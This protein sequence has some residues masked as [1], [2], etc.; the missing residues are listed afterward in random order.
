MNNQ[1]T[2]EFDFIDGEDYVNDD[3]ML[4]LKWDVDP[5]LL[6]KL[7]LTNDKYGVMRSIIAELIVA[8]ETDQ[9]IAY[10]RRRSFYKDRRRYHGRGFT[11][12]R[13]RKAIDILAKSDYVINWIA[14]ARRPTKG[15]KGTQSTIYGMP[16]LIDACQGFIV[17]PI[18]HECIWQRDIDGNWIDYTETEFTIEMRYEIQSINDVMGKIQYDVAMDGVRKT[19]N[20]I[21]IPHKN[22]KD[23]KDVEL[24]IPYGK[25]QLRRVFCRS[26][27]DCGGRLYGSWQNLTKEARKCLTINGEPTAEPDFPSLHPKIAYAY[28]GEFFDKDYDI[29]QERGFLDK[30]EYKLALLIGMNA[31]SPQA[32]IHAIRKKLKCTVQAATI[33]YDEVIDQNSAIRKFIAADKGVEFQKID[34]ELALY[35]IKSCQRNSIPC[36][37]VH[38]SFIVPERFEEKTKEYMKEAWSN[39]IQKEQLRNIYSRYKFPQKGP[40]E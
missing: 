28:V 21:I 35:V 14:P 1:I 31:R 23:R 18:Q 22:K 11:Y 37:P 25:P 6:E 26:S 2:D 9:A 36:L 4:G 24:A 15:R 3:R 32:A 8:S 17:T 7:N 10:S 5:S 27:F 16:K 34:S 40:T 29:Y 38:D 20:H 13:I 39:F 19:K 33:I 30:A 12:A